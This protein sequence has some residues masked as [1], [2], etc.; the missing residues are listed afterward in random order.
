[1]SNRGLN[2]YLKTMIENENLKLMKNINPNDGQLFLTD[3]RGNFVC[4][5]DDEDLEYFPKG[6]KPID[7]FEAK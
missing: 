3:P 6:I 2:S 5:I 7:N 4:L 1:M